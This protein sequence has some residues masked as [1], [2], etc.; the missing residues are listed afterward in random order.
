MADS[1]RKKKDELRKTREQLETI[2]NK[3]LV[4][5]AVQCNMEME[6]KQKYHSRPKAPVTKMVTIFEDIIHGRNSKKV[7]T[8]K[9]SQS[10]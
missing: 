4:E 7:P 5:Q 1:L 6:E 9:L 10:N 2:R 3:K 8:S